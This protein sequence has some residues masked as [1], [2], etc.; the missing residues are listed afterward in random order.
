MNEDDNLIPDSGAEV[1]E[2]GKPS[3]VAAKAAA[4]ATTNKDETASPDTG[5]KDDSE[6]F[7]TSVGLYGVGIKA[8]NALSEFFDK[9]LATMTPD[10]AAEVIWGA[11][12]ANRPR[13]LVGMDAH[14]IHTLGKVLGARYQDVF[15]AVAKRV[16]PH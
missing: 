4:E 7:M 3:E 11:V 2:N 1:L 14:A 13:Q 12:R 15:S 10:K 9:R 16:M 6:A 5:A 8:V